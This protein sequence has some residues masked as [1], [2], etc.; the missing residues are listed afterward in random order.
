MTSQIDVTQVVANSRL[1][2]YQI[3][4]LL[5]CF[6]CMMIDGFDIQSMAYVAP[7][8][9]SQWGIAKASL[10]P[11]F[12]ISL[13]GMLLGSLIFGSV[14]DAIGRRPVL[15]GAH[16]VLA[17]TMFATSYAESITSLMIMRLL[18]GLAMGA[19]VPNAIAMSTEYTPN[20][21]KVT[22]LMLVSSGMVCGGIIGGV[23]AAWLIPLFGWHSVFYA[24]AIAPLIL[25]IIMLA[26]MPESMQWLT[27]RGKSASRVAR[28]LSRINPDLIIND[29]SAI[30]TTAPKKS[31]LSVKGLLGGEHGRGTI[32]LWL[33]NFMN[34]L[35]VYFLASWIPVLMSDAGH[36]ASQSVLAGAA[37]WL[38]G[39][40][41]TWLLGWCV[42]RRGYVAVLMPTFILAGAAI[43]F[44]SRYYI[45]IHWAYLFIAAAGFGV[46]GGQA[47][48][49]AMASTY[50]PTA[51]RS[52]GL[53][54]A[55][56]FGRLGGIMGP[57]L[58]GGLLTL[59]W[60]TA[61][62]LLLSALP[63]GVTVLAIV[64][65]S[66]AHKNSWSAAT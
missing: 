66:R 34:M 40:G 6:A 46:M 3:M 30:T 4:V 13:V 11:V 47:I 37:L 18:S 54:W 19:I 61:N 56:G 39:L 8:I 49:N 41:G 43:V 31:G 17:L 26:L 48:L 27:V 64:V 51:L 57:I 62:L 7:E 28:T 65:F 52:T 24:G 16:I 15:I 44:F 12:G 60:S 45:A 29:A 63:I 5:M 36:S 1:G 21:N 14:A 59:H 38:G 32:L 10:G 9:I 53:G 33:M 50:Y 55:L 35:C 22:L 23:I 42:D 58:G 2:P 20:H 25:A